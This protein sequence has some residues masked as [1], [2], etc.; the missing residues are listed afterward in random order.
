MKH[1]YKELLERTFE[2]EGLLTV[3]LKKDNVPEELSALIDRKLSELIAVDLEYHA[4]SSSSTVEEVEMETAYYALEDEDSASVKTEL[5]S[6]DEWESRPA[7]EVEE[8][9]TDQETDEKSAVKELSFSL[10]DR[11]LY[12][13]TLFGGDAKRF[14]EEMEKLKTFGSF[15]EA[16][17]YLT[18]SL[19]LRP[20]E[21]E[22]EAR[23][24]ELVRRYYTS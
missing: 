22:D 12:I 8:K 13:R 6:L 3:A 2:L 21:N 24:L 14:A 23:L 16:S 11:F 7:G 10:N 9:A 18:G 15:E 1:R 20:E 19:T 4:G 17:S 5:S